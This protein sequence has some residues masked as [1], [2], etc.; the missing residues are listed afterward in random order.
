MAKKASQQKGTGAGTPGTTA[1]A[2]AAP[3]LE[4]AARTPNAT[5]RRPD[6]DQ[7]E[8]VMERE[9]R[10]RGLFVAFGYSGDVEA[11]CAGTHR[12][13][14]RVIKL[15]TVQEILDEQHVQKM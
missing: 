6:I 10:R 4:T 14:G 13:T 15:I 5:P 9:D 12:R 7:F 2:A 1:D 11:E 8:A 3:S